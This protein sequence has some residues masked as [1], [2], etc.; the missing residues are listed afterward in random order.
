MKYISLLISF[1]IK[2]NY[3]CSSLNLSLKTPSSIFFPSDPE[4][5]LFF[6]SFPL[7]TSNHVQFK[8]LQRN[9]IIP[10]SHQMQ[11]SKLMPLR[12]EISQSTSGFPSQPPE[13]SH[14]GGLVIFTHTISNCTQTPSEQLLTEVLFDT[15]AR[16]VLRCSQ[17]P[18]RSCTGS[19]HIITYMTG[20][21]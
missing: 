9:Y 1:Y 19:I 6:L 4:K 5:Y 3:D 11:M 13:E 17:G 7:P 21:M 8:R 16:D 2:E 20:H 10:P 15:Q 14:S 12:E 18:R